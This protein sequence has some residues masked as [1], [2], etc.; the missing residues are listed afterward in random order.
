MAN[1]ENVAVITWQIY[2][3]EKNPEI[4][5]IIIL[6]KFVN[7]H[8]AVLYFLAMLK[9]MALAVLYFLAMLN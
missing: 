3:R 9:Q 6:R 4:M 1:F 8:M 2:K 7:S 5:D